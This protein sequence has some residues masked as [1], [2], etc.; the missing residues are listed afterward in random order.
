MSKYIRCAYKV[1]DCVQQGETLGLVVESSTH[2]FTVRM[3]GTTPTSWRGKGQQQSKVALKHTTSNIEI[4]HYL[5]LVKLERQRP[6]GARP[7]L[8]NLT[9]E[10]ELLDADDEQKN[11]LING[12][13]DRL[14]ETQKK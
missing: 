9:L 8:R 4:K 3:V 10:Q 5:K 7:M 1:G 14:S 2:F 11:S 6:H 12:Y 13:T